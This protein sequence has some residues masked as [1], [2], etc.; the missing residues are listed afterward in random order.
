MSLLGRVITLIFA[1]AFGVFL[2]NILGPIDPVI[3][4]IARASTHEFGV[5][6]GRSN[7]S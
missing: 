3:N 4:T 2:I 6:S 5:L 7:I 1:A